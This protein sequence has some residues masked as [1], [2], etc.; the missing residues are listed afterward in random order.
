AGISSFG[1]SGT[2]AHLIL[3]EPPTTNT[4]TPTAEPIE[5]ESAEPTEHSP[6][7]EIL[8]FS[9]KTE[10]ALHAYAANLANYLQHHPAT[11]LAGQL[12]TR[13]TFPHRATATPTEL[14]N[15]HYTT[16]TTGGKLAILF[17][18]QGAQHPGMGLQLAATNPTFAHHFNEVLTHLDP[19]LRTIM[20]TDQIHQTRY[21]QPALFAYEVALYHTLGL[22]PD[23]LAGHSIGEI[24]AAHLAGTLT[25]P[26]AAKLVTT[27]ANLMQNLPP[28][29]AMATVQTTP[30]HATPHLTGD[31]TIAAINTAN[32][33]T[34]TGTAEHIHTTLHNIP[35][36]SRLLTVSH[37]FHSNHLDPILND[38]T[39]TATTLTHQPPTIPVISNLT[40]QP[41]NHTPHYWAQQ[42]RN[43]VQW[44]NTLTYLADQGV[45]TFLEIGPHNTL[46]TLTRET[47]PNA[48]ALHTSHRT[49][50]TNITTLLAHTWTTGHTNHPTNPTNHLPQAPTYPFQRNRYWLIDTPRRQDAG[51]VSHP[52][53]TA[54]SVHAES[55]STVYS[56]ALS[57]A[58]DP[59]PPTSTLAELVL[60][61]GHELGCP[62]IRELDVDAPLAVPGDGALQV[63]VTVG[64]ADGTGGRRV[65]VHSRATRDG[66]DVA[67][68]RNAHGTLD[69]ATP[70]VPDEVFWP[71]AAAEPM[72]L[73]GSDAGVV[74]AW[75]RGDDI[76][77]EIALA[78]DTEHGY[79]VH[80]ALL[81]QAVRLHG[82]SR[83]AVHWAG[84]SLIGSHATLLRVRASRLGPDSLALI[85][86][87][88]GGEPVLVAESVTVSQ[89]EAP[90]EP[91][92]SLYEVCWVPL[93]TSGS[94]AP[95]TVVTH[96]VDG[97]RDATEAADAVAA[98]LAVVQRWLADDT[99]AGSRLVLVTSGAVA[100][101]DGD[102][103]DLGAAAV[104][105]LIR[106]AQTEHPDR[107]VLVD[108]DPTTTEAQ[109]TAAAR[110]GEPQIAIRDGSFA[111]PRLTRR[112]VAPRSTPSWS[113][114]TVLITGATGDLA[115]VFARHLVTTAG[116]RRLVLA[117]RRGGDA[118][119]M[120]QLCRELT[121]AGAEVTT[122]VCDMADRAAVD[123]LLSGIVDLRAV[124]HT[125]GVLHD[126]VVSG[127][128]AGGLGDVWGPK[129]AGAWHL[130]EATRDRDLTAFVL[131]SSI[132][133]TLG[134]AG[135]AGYA[136]ANAFLDALAQQ[137]WAAGLP[138]TSLAWGLWSPDGGMA[139]HLG[140]ADRARWARTGVL[141]VDADLGV[142][143]FG[144][145]LATDAAALVPARLDGSGVWPGT[146][147]VP[148]MLRG[149]FR[150]ARRR[151]AGATAPAARSLAARL[152][153]MAAHDE[154]R[155]YLL[156]LVRAEAAAV[157]GHES[158]ATMPEHGTFKDAGFDSLA[159]VELRN[160]INQVTG[161][162]LS[163]AL[164]YDYPTPIALAGH[165]LDQ[166][167][168]GTA[169]SDRPVSATVVSDE[170]IAIVGMGCRLPGGVST[171]EQLWQILA[172]GRDAIG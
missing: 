77:A 83:P 138:A 84:L 151:A 32:H 16:G 88:A 100:A 101:R 11:G 19:E 61:A 120:P 22:T 112:E 148:A 94:T 75:R 25:L 169:T 125:A 118:P 50:G 145:A 39:T 109:L 97:G 140:D 171:P 15:N 21:T 72:P 14:R 133:A 136:S 121:D 82:D 17:T 45:T 122:A 23:Y 80:P 43:T 37:A 13:T 24:T 149:L 164:V 78:E 147:P 5:P 87:D 113:D 158:A 117:S 146:S 116:V 3:E 89:I 153:G 69:D 65:T 79:G 63:Q 93:E 96:R 38:L 41:A 27:R 60:Q 49:N 8:A 166:L 40:A 81:D 6:E 163:G 114:G 29:G 98:V 28:T 131:F 139:A 73:A 70:V 142:A 56:G 126:G 137:R 67:W 132:A 66:I 31:V 90:A 51:T 18:G 33:I 30:E 62:R 130:H 99:A 53:L 42:A 110:T 2:N 104:W 12:A 26:D 172:E 167:V 103:P 165:L 156:A 55:N 85:A 68:A 143:L 108:A 1:I 102:V 106:T 47:L 20:N 111:V 161:L 57:A 54:V 36:P 155:A 160:R 48:T 105:G 35:A 124:V 107:I 119:G 71:P 34:I 74:A 141:P 152:A 7:P 162:R 91:A 10:T 150:V 157:L 135:Q 9:A 58:R 59:Q 127:L 44:H 92:T 95:T 134:S 159:A 144:A 154:R 128:D 52:I 4:N 115:R 46:T 123:G 129:A 64:A 76:F 170:P 168:G 86:V